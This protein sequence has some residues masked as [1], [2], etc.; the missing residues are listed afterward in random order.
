[1]DATPPNNTTPPESITPTIED[2]QALKAVVDKERKLSAEMEKQYKDAQRKVS[3]YEK[4][5]AEYKEIDPAKYQQMMEAQKVADFKRLEDTQQ[6]EILKQQ[7]NGEKDR[8]QTQLEASEAKYRD[9]YLSNAIQSAYYNAGGL[10]PE[11]YR[12]PG[13]ESIPPVQSVIDHFMLRGNIKLEHDRIHFLDRLGNP[14]LASDN[15]PKSLDLKMAEFRKG[16]P[17]LFAAEAKHSGIGIP[18]TSHLGN[19][20][21]AIMSLDSARTG[22]ASIADIATGKI[23]IL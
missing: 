19:P 9:Y 22:K 18:P 23:K 17:H 13:V 5:L 21:T 14:E 3:E 16:N 8:L 1:M 4:K 11:P 7:I 10:H 15:T 12:E 20:K 2:L 6:W